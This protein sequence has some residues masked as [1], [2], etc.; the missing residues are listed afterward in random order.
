MG[1]IH[2]VCRGA[3]CRCSFGSAPDQLEIK[4]QHKDYF[5]DDGVKKLVAT[6]K[7]LGQTFKNNS[8]GSCS[9]MDNKPCKVNVTEWLYPREKLTLRNGGKALLETSKASCPIGSPGCIAVVFHGQT[10]EVTHHNLTQGD[11]DFLVELNPFLNLK[12]LIYPVQDG[13][14][15]HKEK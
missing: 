11:D 1:D 12:E 6:T 3:V 2:Y 10:S 7:E 5:N 15:E 4:S 9:K 14:L 8:F 13:M